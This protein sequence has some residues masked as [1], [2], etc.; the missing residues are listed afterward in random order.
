MEVRIGNDVY[1]KTLYS[2][3][4][5]HSSD[6]REDHLCELNSTESVL[7]HAV[8]ERDAEIA[9][10]RTEVLTRNGE[11]LAAMVRTAERDAEIARLRAELAAATED[12]D[13][14]KKKHAEDCGTFG[15]V[16]RKLAA[17]RAALATEREACDE[18]DDHLGQCFAHHMNGNENEDAVLAWREA[19]VARRAAEARRG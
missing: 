3:R 10:L 6:V 16:A 5:R 2:W 15:E 13:W 18:A 1:T 4:V 11:V 19:R 12:R 14:W 7:L 17:A 9:R 8:A